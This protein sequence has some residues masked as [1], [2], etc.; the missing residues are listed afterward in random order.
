MNVHSAAS[1]FHVKELR[2]SLNFYT[3]VLGFEKDFEYG[4]YA[5]VKRGNALIHLSA[6]GTNAKPVG[7]GHIYIFCDRL[8]PTTTILKVKAQKQKER[9]E[10]ILMA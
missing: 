7:S 8:T 10:I 4:E 1:V 5:G 3:E 2:P 6:H 9:P